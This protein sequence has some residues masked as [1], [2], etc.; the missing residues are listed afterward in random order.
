MNI[1]QK[2]YFK[3]F[4]IV[5]I[6]GTGLSI[7]LAVNGGKSD[8]SYFDTRLS[9]DYSSCK[10]AALDYVGISES[11]ADYKAKI[12]NRSYRTVSRD[13]ENFMVTED[14]APGRLNFEVQKDVVTK[15]TCG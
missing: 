13:G 15:V 1:K 6:I 9:D 4:L 2:Q 3:R 8:S 11:Q 12:E 10:K 7:W 5:V 14:Y